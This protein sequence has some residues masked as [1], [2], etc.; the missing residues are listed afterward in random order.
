MRRV[1][2]RRHCSGLVTLSPDGLMEQI[3]SRMTA[4]EVAGVLLSTMPAPFAALGAYKVRVCKRVSS[5]LPEQIAIRRVHVECRCG[6][7]GQAAA[8]LQVQIT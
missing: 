2:Q 7:C 6:R 5:F 3:S 8:A 1:S 4:V